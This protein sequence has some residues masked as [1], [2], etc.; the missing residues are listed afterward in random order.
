[1]QFHRFLFVFLMGPFVCVRFTKA[2]RITTYRE[3]KI[4][5]TPPPSSDKHN[6]DD[7]T[8]NNKMDVSFYVDAD[9]HLEKLQSQ[10]EELR[11]TYNEL[12]KSAFGRELRNRTTI[13]TTKPAPATATSIKD[14]SE[15]VGGVRKA[16]A[17]W[18]RAAINP[19]LLKSK[20]S[21]ENSNETSLEE[22]QITT[23]L[24]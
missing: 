24:K 10:A 9:E 17:D 23:R 8:H 22:T 7:R 15:T 21:I 1:M 4:V 19:M 6:V 11:D 16:S 3:L 18:V 13:T 20:A 14:S 5:E 12:I 2:D